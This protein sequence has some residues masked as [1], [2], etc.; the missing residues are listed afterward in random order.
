MNH[1]NLIWPG[2]KYLLHA[3]VKD[4]LTGFNIFTIFI[5]VINENEKLRQN[6]YE[7]KKKVEELKGEIFPLSKREV[8]IA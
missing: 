5:G 6:L 1:T 4:N 3:A 7:T 2:T 8:L